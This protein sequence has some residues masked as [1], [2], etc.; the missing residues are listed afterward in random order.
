MDIMVRLIYRFIKLL[1]GHTISPAFLI[2]LGVT[3]HTEM[4]SGLLFSSAFAGAL[5]SPFWGAVGDKY[6]RKPMIIR[7]GLVLFVIYILMAFVTN[8]YQVLILRLAGLLSGFIPGAIA[9]VGTNTPR[10]GRL[11]PLHDVHGNRNRRHYG[12]DDRRHPGLPVQQ[13]NGIRIGRDAVLRATRL[14]YS[15]SRKRN[16]CP[17]KSASPS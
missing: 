16:S 8:E 3:K 2:E 15:G 14:S 7:A 11:R 17:A 9:I 1:D 6:G 13:P 12:P 10:K 5:S 4:W